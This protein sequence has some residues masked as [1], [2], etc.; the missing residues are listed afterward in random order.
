[1]GINNK[2]ASLYGHKSRAGFPV[3]ISS[4]TQSYKQFGNAVVPQLVH[5]I[6]DL[7]QKYM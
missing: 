3:G 5:E 7:I 6:G 4:N 1:M 2:Y